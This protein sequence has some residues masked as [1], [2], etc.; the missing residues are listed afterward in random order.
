MPKYVAYGTKESDLNEEDKQ[1]LA[2]YRSFQENLRKQ[3][4]NPFVS[5]QSLDQHRRQIDCRNIS[6]ETE[7]NLIA[8]LLRFHGW[9]CLDLGVE[10]STEVSLRELL[11]SYEDLYRFGVWLTEC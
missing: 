7:N 6:T 9:A 4:N 1:M 8:E 11:L 3:K 10:D 5:G 2:E